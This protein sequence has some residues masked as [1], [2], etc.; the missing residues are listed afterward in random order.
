MA[1]RRAELRLS[2]REASKASG[3]PVATL[4]RIEQG[5]LP[6]LVTFRRL[7]DWLG[8]PPEQFFQS[9]TRTE[10]TPTAIAE[11]L[12]EDPALTPAAAEKI[13]GLVRDLY[14]ALA[15]PERR[16]ALH[17]KTAKTF[18]PAA[19]RLFTEIL[20]DIQGALDGAAE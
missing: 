16:L 11:H 14:E 5:R 18:T 15:A 6:D 8:L 4:A 2:L 3:V 12:R 1:Q 20:D 19:L 17:L 10:N 9:T 13:A 7:V